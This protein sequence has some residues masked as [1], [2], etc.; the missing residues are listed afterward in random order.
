MKLVGELEHREMDL[1]DV[2]EAVAKNFLDSDV[3]KERLRRSLLYPGTQDIDDALPLPISGSKFMRFYFQII[4]FKFLKPDLLFDYE[5]I[6]YYVI[7]Y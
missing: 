3:W 7:S 5:E 2:P 1:D 4:F 6:F